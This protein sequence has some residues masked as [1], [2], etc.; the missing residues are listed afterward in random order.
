MAQ[1]VD[2]V[3]LEARVRTL[4]CVLAA[5][6]HYLPTFDHPTGDGLPCIEIRGDEMHWVVS[7]RGEE[8]ERRTTRDLDELLYWVFAGITFGMAADW[9]VRHRNED[10]DSRVGLFR[11]QLELLAQLNDEWVARRKADLGPILREV[12]LD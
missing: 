10:E 5:P 2:S 11:K 3:Q 7:E 9:E 8:F 6:E 12:G 4:A 1:M